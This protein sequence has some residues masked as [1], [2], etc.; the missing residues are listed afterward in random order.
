[1]KRILKT[2]TRITTSTGHRHFQ[3]PRGILLC[4]A[5]HAELHYCAAAAV[6]LATSAPAG[7]SLAKLYIP[8]ESSP[9]LTLPRRCS[10]VAA[11]ASSQPPA[12]SAAAL[13]SSRSAARSTHTS[14]C[15]PD[16]CAPAEAAGPS[17]AWEPGPTPSSNAACGSQ[18]WRRNGLGPAAAELA[19]LAAAAEAAAAASKAPGAAEPKGQERL[20]ARKGP[21][22]RAPPAGWASR[23]WR[24]G[25][26]A[27]LAAAAPA[28]GSGGAR[29]VMLV[30]GQTASFGIED[31][32]W[33]VTAGW[34]QHWVRVQHR[35]CTG[36]FT[37]LADEGKASGRTLTAGGQPLSPAAPA[38]AVTVVR[39]C[40]AEGKRSRVL[41][42]APADVFIAAH[43]RRRLHGRQPKRGVGCRRSGFRGRLYALGDQ[44]CDCLRTLGGPAVSNESQSAWQSRHAGFQECAP[45]SS[46]TAASETFTF[47]D[48]MLQDIAIAIDILQ[49][50]QMH[51]LL[52]SEY[53]KGRRPTA[54]TA[55]SVVE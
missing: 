30:E 21:V 53:Y 54:T 1:M 47:H 42:P 37:R 35:H 4:A 39:R 15:V 22:L 24:I 34:L 36:V 48:L 26:T 13:A 16:G 44:L 2:T 10:S 45:L 6:W 5:C 29:V 32:A 46:G 17:A 41:R 51:A 49:I 27:P 33:A 43:P 9:C 52:V 7:Y 14:G 25:C 18:L 50:S 40:C 28:H 23:L 31:L 8:P 38:A 20:E 55:F 19:V 12:D 3:K 11:A